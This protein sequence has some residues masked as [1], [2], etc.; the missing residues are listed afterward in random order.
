MDPEKPEEFMKNIMAGSS[1][2]RAGFAGF[3]S[4]TAASYKVS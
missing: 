4:E 3:L 1:V 2:A